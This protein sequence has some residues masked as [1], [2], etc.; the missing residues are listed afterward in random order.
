MAIS[1]G[2]S[3]AV[4]VEKVYVING[5]RAGSNDLHRSIVDRPRVVVHQSPNLRRAGDFEI[6]PFAEGCVGMVCGVAVVA[7]EPRSVNGHIATRADSLRAD[8]CVEG[9]AADNWYLL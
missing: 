9:N 5:V 6:A 7:V 2:E 8:A 3:G 4:V 1:E